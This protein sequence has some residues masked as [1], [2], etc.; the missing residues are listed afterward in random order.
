ML[1]LVIGF[2]V[3]LIVGWNFLAQ[4]PQVKAFIDK[5]KAKCGIE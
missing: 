4:P 5:I 2:V 1:P 3:G